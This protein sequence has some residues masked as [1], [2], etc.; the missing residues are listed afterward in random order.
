MSEMR[1]RRREAQRVNP[2]SIGILNSDASSPL[3]VVPFQ[4]S[5][6]SV[7]HQ[8]APFFVLSAAG[9]NSAERTNL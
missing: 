9:S 8:P 7:N 1:I 5:R 4:V 2:E 6:E 3:F